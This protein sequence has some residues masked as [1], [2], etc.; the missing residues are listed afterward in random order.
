MVALIGGVAS[1]FGGGAAATTSLAT[2]GTWA[3]ANAGGA[4]AAS[5]VGSGL[6]LASIL[7]GT[8]TVLGIVSSISA[9]NENAA[10]LEMQAADTD[11][12]QPL[13]TLQGIER[14]TSIKRAMAD[15]LGAQD[16]AYAASGVDL[17]FGTAA[18]ARKDAYREADVALTADAGT[19][20]TRKIRLSERA[21]SY[22]RSAKQAKRAG[23]F[24]GLMGGL[25]GGM[26]FLERG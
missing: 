3:A 4:I 5:T 12:E 14:R 19:E 25:K 26:S 7:Q 15:A 18:N 24:E 10:A 9:G 6:S 17:S 16:V 22:R 2:A 13:E 20:A 23:L 11:R 1:L 21:A 8:A